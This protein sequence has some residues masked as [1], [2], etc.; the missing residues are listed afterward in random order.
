M[1]TT[2]SVRPGHENWTVMDT[3]RAPDV[4]TMTRVADASTAYALFRLTLGFT[5]LMHGISKL[6]TGLPRFVGGMMRLFQ[7]TLLA[8]WATRAF[9]TVLP[10][11]E[12]AIGVLLVLGLATRFALVLGMALMC[13]L[14]FGTSLVGQSAIVTQELLYAAAFAAMLAVAKW[15]RF[16]LDSWSR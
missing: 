7:P 3:P 9:A 1:T 11:V 13:A 8:P 12:L 14:I 16:G 5:M 6:V 2:G 10:F 15:N 4:R